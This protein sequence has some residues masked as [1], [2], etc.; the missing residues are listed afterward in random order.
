MMGLDNQLLEK[1]I[2]AY[3]QVYPGFR[4][5]LDNLFREYIRFNR[6]VSCEHEWH[7]VF[8]HKIGECFECCKCLGLLGE[9]DLQSPIS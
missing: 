3:D 2:N 8:I 9:K 5:V 4:E 6:D 7:K 1:V